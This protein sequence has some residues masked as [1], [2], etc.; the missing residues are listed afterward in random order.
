[1]KN[2]TATP[3][4]SLVEIVINGVSHQSSGQLSIDFEDTDHV[5]VRQLQGRTVVEEFVLQV[6]PPP[7]PRV[8]EPRGRT[9]KPKPVEE[10]KGPTGAEGPVGD[11]GPTG[12]PSTDPNPPAPPAPTDETKAEAENKEET[13]A[14][15]SE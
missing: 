5:T 13:K 3:T 8:T 11:P 14:P 6:P 12:P 2:Y 7:K 9:E 1:M 10:S 4:H 15:A